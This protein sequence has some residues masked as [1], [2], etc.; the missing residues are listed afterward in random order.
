MTHSQILA[1]LSSRVDYLAYNYGL[2]HDMT[3]AAIMGDAA[4]FRTASRHFTE[5]M[6]AVVASLNEACG[7]FLFDRPAPPLSDEVACSEA[8]EEILAGLVGRVAHSRIKDAHNRPVAW[9]YNADGTMAK[10]SAAFSYGVLDFYP[11][12]DYLN[13]FGSDAIIVCRE[14]GLVRLSVSKEHAPAWN[15]VPGVSHTAIPVHAKMRDF[16]ALQD[17]GYFPRV[18]TSNGGAF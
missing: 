18:I 12:G 6:D 10:G 14:L 8:H 17:A 15:Q 7:R 9:T 2:E 16:A 5:S 1:L 13:C 3:R 11:W 4:G